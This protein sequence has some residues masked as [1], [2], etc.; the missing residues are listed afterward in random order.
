M[1][2]FWQENK[3]LNSKKFCFCISLVFLTQK[4]NACLQASVKMESDFADNF[5]THR[6]ERLKIVVL[7]KQRRKIIRKHFW[8]QSNK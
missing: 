4:S 3:S 7:I 2:S 1:A 5:S 6:K 8:K